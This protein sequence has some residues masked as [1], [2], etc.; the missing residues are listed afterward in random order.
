MKNLTVAEPSGKC[1]TRP[2]HQ[3]ALLEYLSRKGVGNVC[4]F[5]RRFP[6]LSLLQELFLRLMIWGECLEPGRVGCHIEECYPGPGSAH[7]L[8]HGRGDGVADAFLA[9]TS[10]CRLRGELLQILGE[11]KPLIV[12]DLGLIGMHRDRELRSL[13][14]QVG[15]SLGVVRRYL[16]DRH[17]LLSGTRPGVIEWLRAFMGRGLFDYSSLPGDEAASLRGA[18]KIIVLD[19]SAESEL[20]GEDIINADAFIIGGIVDIVPRP[21]ATQRLGLRGLGEP[22]KIVLRG[23]TVG[24]P[25]RIPQ[26]VEIIMRARFETCGDVEEAVRR[27]MSPRDARLRAFVELMRWSRGKKRKVPISFYHE[28]KKW[29]PISIRD[30]VR[31]AKMAKMDIVWD[32]EKAQQRPNSSYK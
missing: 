26:V 18:N 25:S 2:R 27:T 15:A 10:R 7:C 9:Y 24:V 4:L 12:V 5:H 14:V 8:G 20:S 1:G 22:R 31:A 6:R 11:Y 17:L 16:W 21:G 3:E 30:F 28:L 32:E 29:L 13:R 19:P 23:S